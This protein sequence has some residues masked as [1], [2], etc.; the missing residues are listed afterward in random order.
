MTV[1]IATICPFCR[2]PM[3]LATGIR[4]DNGPAPKDGDFSICIDCGEVAIFE[5]ALPG[6]MRPP[7]DAEAKELALDFD[8]QMARAAWRETQ[9]GRRGPR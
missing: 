2:E 7:T 5:L 8:V 9:G 6:K 1:E 4:D 3:P